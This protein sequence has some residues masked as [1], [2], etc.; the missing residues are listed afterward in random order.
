MTPVT[1]I[2]YKLTS[3]IPQKYI[4]AFGIDVDPNEIV[5]IKQESRRAVVGL[6]D[7]QAFDRIMD[8]EAIMP[9]DTIV[10]HDGYGAY[11]FVDGVRYGVS[12]IYVQVDGYRYKAYDVY[13]QTDGIRYRMSK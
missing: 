1:A 10:Q 11:V 9:S 8:V 4:D 13:T 2:G 7:P 5:W 6:F 12:A 3:A